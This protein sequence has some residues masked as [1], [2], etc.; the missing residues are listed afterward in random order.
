MISISP[1]PP[2][3]QVFTRHC[4]QSHSGRRFVQ[5]QAFSAVNFCSISHG[6]M[7]HTHARTYRDLRVSP[8]NN[9]NQEYAIRIYRKRK[10][11]IRLMQYG[12]KFPTDQVF[13][14]KFFHSSASLS[15]SNKSFHLFFCQ[16]GQEGQC[17]KKFC[18]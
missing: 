3:T 17:L 18:S 7:M 4:H 12:R 16:I 8:E 5:P 15:S 14:H 2:T 1:L 9:P 11:M 10:K 6:Q 13:Q